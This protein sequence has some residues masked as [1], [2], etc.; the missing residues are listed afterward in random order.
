MVMFL[1]Y[2]GYHHVRWLVLHYA[3]VGFVELVYRM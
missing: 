3:V 1:V 2:Y